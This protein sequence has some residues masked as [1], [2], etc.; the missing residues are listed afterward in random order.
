MS[1]GWQLFWI[2]LG[3]VILINMGCF[4][5]AILGVI[6]VMCM[7]S[8]GSGNSKTPSNDEDSDK[9]YEYYNYTKKEI[10]ED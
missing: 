4:G 7:S 1:G 9:M 6:A 5:W 2:A 10:D 3:F 8:G